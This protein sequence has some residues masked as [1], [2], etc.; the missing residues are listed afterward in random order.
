[1][2][3]SFWVCE[4]FSSC[5]SVRCAC[6][7]LKIGRAHLWASC[8]LAACGTASASPLSPLLVFLPFFLF[9][10]R[11]AVVTPPFS[12]FLLFW[13]PESSLCVCGQSCVPI[14][15]RKHDTAPPHYCQSSNLIENSHTVAQWVTESVS[16]PWVLDSVIL[17]AHRSFIPLPNNEDLVLKKG[18]TGI[19]KCA[20]ER[21]P[22]KTPNIFLFRGWRDIKHALV[23][24][25]LLFSFLFLP[26]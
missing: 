5:L 14:K 8:L 6:G 13:G 25:E 1:M 24:L 2:L 23:Q 20:F 3:K 4:C 12:V 11:V 26:N 7:K 18:D 17:E 15:A 19:R 21:D 22:R 16:V 9:F 10:C